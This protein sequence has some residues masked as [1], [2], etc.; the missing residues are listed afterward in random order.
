MRRLAKRRVG[1]NALPE[2]SL[3][4]LSKVLVVRPEAACG[5]ATAWKR[6]RFWDERA[7]QLT[8]LVGT[9]WSVWAAVH[10]LR[11]VGQDDQTLRWVGCLVYAVSLVTVYVSSFLSHSFTRPAWR[12]AFRT[13]DQLAIFLLIAGSYTPV[14][15]V[16]CRDGPWGLVL[17][18]MWSMAFLGIWAKL[19]LA[20]LR[21]VS[22][23]YYLATAWF[24]LCAIPRLVR[25]LSLSEMGWVV[26]GAIAYTGGVSFLLND[27]RAPFLHALWHL[28]V[29][30][31]SYCHYQ[32]IFSSVVGR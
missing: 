30:A 1:A 12:H 31:G 4:P 20:G 21:N 32:A 19:R 15:L 6:W 10:L 14:G 23:W 25:V 18:G 29:L 16:Y 7:N 8:H 9:V 5:R 13:L 26:A 27:R 17:V 28:S 11:A 2:V 22:V 3:P 24:A